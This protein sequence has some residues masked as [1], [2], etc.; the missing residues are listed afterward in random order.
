LR[1]V[2]L[3]VGLHGR[4]YCVRVED[5]RNV[6][7]PSTHRRRRRDATVELSCVGGV[8]SV[9]DSLATVSTSLNKFADNEVES[10]RAGGVNAPVGSR[11]PVYNSAAI[12]YGCRI[13]NW[14]A[15]ADGCVHT[16]DTTQLGRINSQ[17]QFP[18]F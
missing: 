3:Q 2:V 1:C 18:N 11:D 17:V 15:T 14:V 16:A 6:F 8:Y 10:L 4:R 5:I 7:K 12:A 13:V 9:A